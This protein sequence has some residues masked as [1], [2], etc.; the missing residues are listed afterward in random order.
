MNAIDA[1]LVRG[2]SEDMSPEERQELA[3]EPSPTGG[4][5]VHMR[6]DA[7]LQG[8]RIGLKLVGSTD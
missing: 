2:L 5:L 6:P 1:D 3:L 7:L 8:T 4:Q